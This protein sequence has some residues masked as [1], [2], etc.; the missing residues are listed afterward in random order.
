MRVVWTARA[1]R[2]LASLR[3]YIVQDDTAAAERQVERILAAAARLAEF[4]ET[5]R[6]GRRAE[7]RELVVSRTPYLVPYRVRGE[8]VEVLRVL[9]GRQRWPEAL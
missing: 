4:P 2:D 5:G 3:N 8:F 1:L 6:P 9:H 7:T